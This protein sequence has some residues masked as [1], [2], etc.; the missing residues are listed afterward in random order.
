MRLRLAVVLLAAS[1][2]LGQDPPEAPGWHRFG[3]RAGGAALTSFHTEIALGVKGT[4]AGTDID[5]EDDLG[6]SDSYETLRL[7]GFWRISRSHRIDVSYFEIERSSQRTV[8]RDIDFGEINIPAGSYVNAF[9]DTEILKFAYRWTFLP[10]DTW[11]LS[12][13]FGF[14]IMRIGVG[15][16]AD[17]G[18]FARTEE[19][20]TAAPLPVLGLHFQWN[21]TAELHL[22][23]GSE[24]FYVA[25][26]DVGSLDEIEGYLTDT[27]VTLEWDLLDPLTFGIGWNLFTSSVDLEQS[28][29]ELDFDY[30]YQGVLFY[31]GL[32]F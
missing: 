18:G 32:N 25:L 13:S 8:D 29:L 26:E 19:L 9:V 27:R 4:S 28:R 22:I 31:A 30:R 12:A 23:A 17:V 15:L 14:H 5:F 2:L 10:E 20:H 1:P 6:F 3:L 24:A 11:E 16:G 7:D 21:L